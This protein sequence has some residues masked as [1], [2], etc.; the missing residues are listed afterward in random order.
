MGRKRI[1]AKIM[2]SD[3][4]KFEKL[5]LKKAIEIPRGTTLTYKEIAA[6]IGRPKAYRAVGNALSKNP[7]APEVP[8]H[9]VIRSDG[10]LG[11]YSGPGGAARKLKMLKDECAI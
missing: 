4:T 6:A 11:G 8:C 5:V 7:F 10:N 3:L 1:L 2:A 9:R